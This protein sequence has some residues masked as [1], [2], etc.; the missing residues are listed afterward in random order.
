[1]EEELESVVQQTCALSGPMPIAAYHP[2]TG[3]VVVK[4]GDPREKDMGT[5]KQ[6]DQQMTNHKEIPDILEYDPNF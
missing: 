4:N 5:G 1:M 2:S 3:L 6:V